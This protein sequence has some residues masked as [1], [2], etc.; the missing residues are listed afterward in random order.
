MRQKIKAYKLPHFIE[1]SKLGIRKTDFGLLGQE[2]TA[3]AYT[4]GSRTEDEVGLV[5]TYQ[6]VQRYDVAKIEQYYLS[7]L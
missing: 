7:S 2:D 5:A 3:C 4:D 6:M 1:K